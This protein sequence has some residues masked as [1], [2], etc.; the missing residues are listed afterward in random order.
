MACD[1]ENS[2]PM[3]SRLLVPVAALGLMAGCV[4]VAPSPPSKDAQTFLNYAG[5]PIDNFTYLGRYYGVRVLGGPYVA[6]W[7]TNSDG[8]LIKVMEPC[9]N[10]PFANKIDLTSASRTVTRNYDYVIVGQDR[11]H[12][13]TIQRLDIEAM[14]QAHIVGP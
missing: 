5:P 3:L 8:Y 9:T 4:T 2:M 7:T 11:C 1:E 10:L 6:L 14:K 12:I 13:D